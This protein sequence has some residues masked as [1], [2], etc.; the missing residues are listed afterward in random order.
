MSIAGKNRRTQCVRNCRPGAVQ[1]L[2]FGASLC[3]FLLFAETGAAQVVRSAAGAAPAD[4]T[5]SRDQFRTDLG[6]GTVAGANGSF[7][8]LRREINWDGVPASFSAPNN[9]PADFFNVNSP[10]GAIFST[11]G[12]GFQVSGASTDS[13]TGQP[14]PANFGNINPTYTTTFQQF[15]PQRLFTALGSNITD[16]TFFIPGTNTPT[17]VSGFG[18]IFTDVDNSNTTSIQFFDTANNSLG[19][20]FVPAFNNGLSFLGV[21]FANLVVARVRITSGTAALG[22]NDA[23][24]GTD[25]VVMDDFIYGEPAVADLSVIKMGPAT[26]NAPSLIN[27]TITLTNNGPGAATNV[28]LT[29]VPP[30]GTLANSMTQNSG[31][32]FTGAFNGVFF[33]EAIANLAAGATAT[34]TVQLTVTR[35]TLN[36]A[37]ITNGVSVTSSTPDPNPAN[38][39]AT[40]AT[41]VINPGP[42]VVISEFRLRGPAGSNDEFIELYNDSNAPLTVQAT[43]ISTGW[44]LLALDTQVRCI[45]SNGTIIPARGHFLCAND[46][47]GSGYSLGGYPGGVSVNAVPDAT[48]SNDIAEDGGVVLFSSTTAFN[49]F[50]LLDAVSFS[51][52]TGSLTREGS[53][54]SF[55]PV[56]TNTEHSFVRKLVTGIPQ[57]TND[58][59]ADFVLV[60]T[61]GNATLSEAQ[62]GA[63]GPENLVAPT[64]R[65]ATIKASLIEPL[66]LTSTPPNRVRDLTPVT[67]GSLGTLSIRR[68]FTN[69]TGSTVNRLRFRAVNITTLGTPISTPPQAD[70]RLLTSGD[71]AVSTSLGSLTVR[72]TLVEQPP[73]QPLG[74]GL[75]S[76]ASLALPG[77]GIAPGA[78]ID[79]QFLLGV[80]MAGTFRF[81]VNVEGLTNPPTSAPGKSGRKLFTSGNQKPPGEN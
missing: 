60:A 24:T 78:S 17:P 20:F 7:G 54:L 69:N 12:T 16:V 28:L 19:T 52:N 1:Y 9:L 64:Q 76:S 8:G 48:Y 66:E 71:F 46:T 79:V 5:P 25:V 80:E 14:A 22:P 6:G 47:P 72:G 67:N 74:G 59:A 39:T 36:G 55:V 75:N 31:P 37:V 3:L 56:T 49:A 81:F 30:P 62:L 42:H 51:G 70:L 23:P 43:D 73:A 27:Y 26:I 10:R 33:T 65:N 35:S 40:V 68:R 63:P 57:D 53:G 29:E 15:S 21:S 45:I 41:T 32:V 50:T 44:A 11:P 58:N 34:F 13:G 4:I 38:N 61:S 18:A 2:C 77:G